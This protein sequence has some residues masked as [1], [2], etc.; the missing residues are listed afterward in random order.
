MNIDLLTK[1]SI[2][3]AITALV[4]LFLGFIIAL[5]TYLLFRRIRNNLK[6]NNQHQLASVISDFDTIVILTIVFVF[7]YLGLLSIKE[8]RDGISQFNQ[9][10]T[11]LLVLLISYSLI[12]AKNHLLEWYS[13]K[14]NY[15]NS[16]QTKV[17]KTL[18]PTAHWLFTLIIVSLAI[19]I[20]LDI[21]GISIAPLIAGL[22]IGG[23]AVALALQGTLSNFF[24]GVNVLTDGSIRVGDYVELSE[25]FSGIV[26]GIGWRTT[27]IRT[28]GNN[29]VIL[30]NNRLADTI[31]TNYSFPY[32][33]MSVYL[34]IGVGYFEDLAYVENVVVEVA[35]EVLLN[36][37]GAVSNYNP[38]V[39]YEEFGDDNI[40]F[41]AVLRAKGYFESWAVKHEF[42]KAISERFKKENI[43][44]SF[45][46]TNIF[47]RD[48][49]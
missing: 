36:T 11:I 20:N 18:I 33:E 22:G 49:S 21:I 40:N 4:I 24:A 37:E 5:I 30:P 38:T 9:V 7:I 35:K 23:L 43:E 26:T 10:F 29:T 12:K 27:R 46:N 34:R 25:G 31:A 48:K 6:E 42:I 41:W 39:W 15:D 16:P 28:L 8:L 19:L 17:V 14:I 1:I 44:I 3:E 2:T 13:E 32:D 47:M 45:H